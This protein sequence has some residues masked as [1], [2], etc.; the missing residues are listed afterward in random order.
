MGLMTP[1]LALYYVGLRLRAAAAQALKKVL[2][3]SLLSAILRH[4]PIK[5]MG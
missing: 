3:E 1:T 2:P 5:G 4:R